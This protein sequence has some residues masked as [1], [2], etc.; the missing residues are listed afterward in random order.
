[1]NQHFGISAFSISA[2]EFKMKPRRIVLKILLALGLVLLITAFTGFFFPQQ[3]LTVDSGPVKAD[4]LVVLGGGGGERTGRAAELFQ[5]GE[6]A[7]I[8]VSGADDCEWTERWLETNVV[9]ASAVLLED[10]SHTTYEN[11]KFSIPMLR[12]LGAHRIIIVT[13]WYHSRRA[14]ACF[15]HLAPDPS[16]IRGRCIWVMIP[17]IAGASG[18]ICGSNIPNSSATGCGTEFVRFKN[19]TCNFSP[20]NQTA[21]ETKNRFY[22][23][24]IEVSSTAGPD[25]DGADCL[26]NILSSLKVRLKT[27]RAAS[28]IKKY[29]RRRRFSLR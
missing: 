3:V 29:R 6:A 13:S 1:L 20:R 21:P 12:A 18:I 11:A 7:K 17:R 10:R 15:E 28:K 23:Y 25:T 2:F 8:I 5:A 4:V 27:N 22:L 16:F 9:P 26:S 24:S 19:L 14:L